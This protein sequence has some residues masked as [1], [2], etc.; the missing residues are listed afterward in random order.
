VCFTAPRGPI[1][2]DVN[3]KTS[4]KS[5]NDLAATDGDGSA[6]S[7]TRLVVFSDD[8]GRHP[9]S[10]QHLIGRLLDRYETIWV[11]T[12][13]TRSPKLSWEDA[14]KIA[15]KLRQWLRPSAAGDKWPHGLHVVSPLMYPGFRRP[16]QRKLNAR[17]ITAKLHQ[18]LGPRQPGERRVAVTTIPIMADLVAKLDVDRWVYYCVDDFSVWPGLDGVALDDME[19]LLV[20]RAD[21]IVC[22]SQ[23]LQ[24]RIAGMGG[25]SDLLTHGVDVDHWRSE[26]AGNAELPAWWNKLPPPVILFWGV[27]DRRLDT[28]WCEAL[29]SRCGTLVLVGPQQSPP[30]LTKLARICLP[31]PEPYD[32]LPALAAAADVLV[33]P[34]ADLPVTRAIQPLKFKEYL[35]TGKPVVVRRLPATTDW[36]DAADVVDTVE[37]LVRVTAERID[38]GAPQEQLAARRRLAQESWPEKAKCFSHMLSSTA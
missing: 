5:D 38:Q 8:W 37:Q 23:T 19:R 11:N 35:A 3:S 18:L 25:Q 32:F 17:L 6:S 36:Q 21:R 9:S 29:A 7:G 31:G 12:I 10:C 20:R 4:P 33:M 15:V 14:G 13:G 24:A 34:Y 28:D 27:V 30:R 1:P 2:T 16:W 22:A 26:S